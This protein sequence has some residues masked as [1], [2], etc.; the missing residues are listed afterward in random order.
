[1][2][3]KKKSFIWCDLQLQIQSFLL[4]FL[5]NE[6]NEGSHSGTR[7]SR[8][9]PRHGQSWRLWPRCS[10]SLLWANAGLFALSLSS[11]NAMCH[12][13]KSAQSSALS[14]TFSDCGSGFLAAGLESPPAPTAR[15]RL[16]AP[17]WYSW[18]AGRSWSREHTS[19]KCWYEQFDEKLQLLPYFVAV[20]FSHHPP[21][22]HLWWASPP[23][24]RNLPR[25]RTSSSPF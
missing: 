15:L 18:M 16:L 14:A 1:M 25:F 3:P 19:Q 23:S 7:G 4:T 11:P 8:N 21:F 20:L 17:G 12:K 9:Y 10:T 13:Q 5:T 2:Q 6:N 24:Q 22:C